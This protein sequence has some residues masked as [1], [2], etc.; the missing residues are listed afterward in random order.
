MENQK[1]QQS[2]T[3]TGQSKKGNG[4]KRLS[5]ACLVLGIIAT[6]FGII[7]LTNFNDASSLRLSSPSEI[8]AQKEFQVKWNT[9]QKE[10][11]QKWDSTLKAAE[12]K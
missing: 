8:A 9:A 5:M 1:I 4:G 6:V 11:E 3:S 7:W 12:H 10:A 2:E